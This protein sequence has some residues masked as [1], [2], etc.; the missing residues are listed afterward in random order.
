[1]MAVKKS[2]MKELKDWLD[3]EN[4]RK[5]TS[6][7][8]TDSKTKSPDQLAEAGSFLHNHCLDWKLL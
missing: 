5:K 4:F 6:A 1:M 2:L 3:S 7:C 8:L